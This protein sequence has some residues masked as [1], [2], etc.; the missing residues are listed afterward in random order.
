MK[1][2]EECF[3]N[4]VKEFTE[5]GMLDFDIFLKMLSY[6]DENWLQAKSLI[7]NTIQAQ[8]I[9]QQKRYFDI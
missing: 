8:N 4:F 6:I 1:A 9:G 7:L 5:Y 2:G 3:I